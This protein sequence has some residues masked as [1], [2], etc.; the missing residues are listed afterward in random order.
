M[1]ITDTKNTKKTI[2]I[3][4]K[5]YNNLTYFDQYAGTVI[6]F[7]II[8]ILLFI[9]YS[10]SIVKTKSA[11]IVS[12]WQEN[13]CKLNI[14]PFAGFITT[15]SGVSP[16]DYTAENFNYCTQQIL[17]GIT[18]PAISPF[19]FITSILN[20]LAAGLL[21]AIQSIRALFARIRALIE[22][23]ITNVMN[24]L[25]NIIIP[26]QQM[27]IKVK[28]M[29]SKSQ[30]LMTVVIY[31]AMGAY[32][33]LQ[34]LLGAIAEVIEDILIALAVMFA[35]V[36]AIATIMMSTPFTMA[37]APIYIAIATA[38]LVVFLAISVPFLIMLVMMTDVLH[39]QGYTVPQLKCFDKNTLITMNDGS[40]K[41]ISKIKAGEILCHNNAVT[42][43][44]RV[45]TKG[46]IMYRLNDIVV[47]DTHIVN[48]NDKWIPVSKHPNAIICIDYNEPYLYCLNTNNKTIVINNT[49][50]TDW[51]E[52]YGEDITNI[53]Y[54]NSYKKLNK[55][56]LIHQELDGGF[57]ESTII[58][59]ENNI[60]KE[61]K[62]IQIGD[63]LINGEIVYGLV[64][65]DGKNLKD[66]FKFILG[67]NVIIEGGPNLI[68]KNN[69][70]L[71]STLHLNTSKNK[72]KLEENNKKLYHLLT[73]KKTFTINNIQFCDYNAA[74]DIFLE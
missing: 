32:E 47:S 56:E 10:Y 4:E 2:S 11:S 61:I 64:E 65:I 52:I 23:I 6:I 35:V 31:F 50:F 38:I 20:V 5:L 16:L 41:I 67:E 27:F 43:I 62:D 14:I 18:K 19:A 71:F 28:D 33:S 72:I 74:I 15:P 34:A 36:V 8:T 29:M 53:M 66:Q 1:E 17:A 40:Q 59:L 44:I 9:F 3:I 39:I 49:V 57:K 13:R 70:K 58:E 60:W 22:N 25:I 63:K 21:D 24:R 7:I 45:Q 69:N 54:N 12:N 42:G 73:D 46:S 55:T 30:G 68:I 51:D 48:Y 26:L 37:T